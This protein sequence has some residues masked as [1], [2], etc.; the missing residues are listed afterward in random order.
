MFSP[1]FHASGYN[2][3]AASNDYH[4]P[5]ELPIAPDPDFFVEPD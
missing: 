2:D 5:L 1:S 3:L 4:Q